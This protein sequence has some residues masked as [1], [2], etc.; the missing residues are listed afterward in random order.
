MDSP[1][2]VGSFRDGLYFQRDSACIAA[3]NATDHRKIRRL[4][5]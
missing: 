2:R 5:C 3:C 4:P 1:G